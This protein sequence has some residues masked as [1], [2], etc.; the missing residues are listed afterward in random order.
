MDRP[1]FTHLRDPSP[2][3]EKK[4]DTS[5]GRTRQ[6]HKDEDNVAFHKNEKVSGPPAESAQATLPKGLWGVGCVAL[7]PIHDTCSLPLLLAHILSLDVVVIFSLALFPCCYHYLAIVFSFPF[8]DGAYTTP[9]SLGIKKK[10][11]PPPPTCVFSSSPPQ[12]LFFSRFFVCV[13]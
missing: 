1:L 9:D 8:C 4:E 6:R 7:F 2:E 12:S 13:C 11:C 3:R 5:G 10:T